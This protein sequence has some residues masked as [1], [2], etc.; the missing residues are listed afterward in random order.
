MK[1]IIV[2]IL[3]FAKFMDLQGASDKA[4]EK[5]CRYDLTVCAVFQQEARFLKEW[6]EYHKLIGVQH[7]IL[8]DDRSSD[9]YME[10]LAPYI[11]SGEVELWRIPYN[12]NLYPLWVDYQ[13]DLVAG[14]IKK[15][16]GNSRWVACIDIDEFIVPMEVD[17]LV[18]FLKD[19][20][21]YGGLYIRW[22]PFG[23]S[24]IEKIPENMLM[25]ECL[26]KRMRFI[27]GLELLGKE[28]VKPHRVQYCNVHSC[29]L[30]P[31][32]QAIDSNPGMQNEFPKIKI[33]HYW[34][35]DIDFLL[36]VKRVRREAWTGEKWS[37]EVCNGYIAMYNDVDD[38]TML[39]FVEKLR[40]RV[41][42]QEE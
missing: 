27:K 11:A 40:R 14:F 35:R 17:N 7:F 8:C 12:Q 29:G 18:D 34:T 41:F 31:P 19:Y 22:E 6:I 36:N 2:G 10:V 20:E 26:T 39:R 15:T 25:T 32:F 23:T 37:P 33:F 21:A 4:I 1:T 13:K 3:L 38:F 5:R 9:N 42:G 16:K 30:Y 24:F 28:I